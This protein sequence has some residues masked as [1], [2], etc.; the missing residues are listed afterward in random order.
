MKRL[1]LLTLAVLSLSAC[2]HEA[3]IGRRFRAE[4][5]LWQANWEYRNLAIRPE[6]VPSTRWAALA[7]T[8][9]AVAE[10]YAPP[11]GMPPAEATEERTL[12]IA[13]RSL[14]A[15]ARVYEQLRDSS[16][17][18]ATYARM[19]ERFAAVP[20][21][22]AEVALAQA[23]VAEG[24]GD[25]QRAAQHYQQVVDRVPPDP[26][27]T[28]AAGVVLGLPLQIARLYARSSPSAPPAAP[29]ARAR[30][31]YI[32][33]VGRED[34]ADADSVMTVEPTIR[35]EALGYLAEIAVDLRDYPRALAALE[36]LEAELTSL[37]DPPR[38][39]CE[40]RFAIAGVQRMAA[41]SVSAREATLQSL[42]T[43]YPD[44]ELAPQALMNLAESAN[45]AGE[46]SAALGYLDRIVDDYGDDEDAAAEAL[47]A[48][49]RLL[50]NRDRWAEAL[51]AFRSVS[52]RYPITEAALW[53][54][55][56]I[57]KHYDR[58][59]DGEATATALARAERTYRDFVERYPPGPRSVFARERLIQ[60]LVLQEKHA[61]AVAE[62]ERL[63]GELDGTRQGAS[64]RIAAAR[65]AYADLADTARAA[66]IL[67]RTG[68]A[69]ADREIG[70]WATDQARR[71]R[72][73]MNP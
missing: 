40:V 62:M 1:L 13:A 59:G 41:A 53:A 67:A 24:E 33:F 48:R 20:A 27:G 66:G 45:Q 28:G 61:E 71:M 52:A 54:P 3:G 10:R 38:E 63:G 35:L 11:S 47:L 29:Y 26:S 6:D 49:G 31:Y 64:L 44:C 50:E 15:A 17:V 12:E 51:E 16:R 70:A 42:L 23:R 5:A 37:A 36:R 56:E 14:F 18:E 73:A 21:V 4:R 58:I 2:S 46:V 34:G 65:M 43:D 68:E 30:E 55:I 32:D 69:Y 25:W 19:A 72:G 22:A 60:A 7:E 8:Y 39:P 9:E 57:A